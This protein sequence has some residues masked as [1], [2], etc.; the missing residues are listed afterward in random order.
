MLGPSFTY[1]YFCNFVPILTRN[2]SSPTN[3]D[4]LNPLIQRVLSY[5]GSTIYGVGGHSILISI[6]DDIAVKVSYKAGGEHLRHEQ[7][8]F[9][10]L[11]QE[12]CPYIA[13]A[14]FYAPD[15]IFM[16]LL[17]NGTLYERLEQVDKPR[18]ILALIQ[19][20]SE[21]AAALENIGFAH[22]DINP[23]NILFDEQDRLRLVDFD[24]ALEIGEVVEVGYEPYVRHHRVDYGTAGPET[25][26]F[27][28]GSVF[29]FMTRGTEVYADIDGAERVKRLSR[30]IFPAVD[31]ADPIDAIISDCWQGKFESIAALS[32]RV[33]QVVFDASF[34]GKKRLCE[35]H[36]SC[37]R[38]AL[39]S[40]DVGLSRDDQP[41]EGS[42]AAL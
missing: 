31:S 22:G 23:R 25:E 11:D 32:R 40:N 9:K 4:N 42:S 6:S 29:W 39:D 2:S 36:Y 20:L 28:L 8:V 10:L 3:A 33:R 34:E 16:G 5:S 27:A 12:A 1:E 18:S 30:R 14:Y 26:Q 24:H 15:L 17:R 19:Q 13:R 41:P 21:A 38:G 35:Q 7:S 37:L